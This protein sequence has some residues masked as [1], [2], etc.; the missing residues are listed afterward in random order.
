MFSPWAWNT[1]DEYY[2]SFQT[3]S[4]SGHEGYKFPLLDGDFWLSPDSRVVF[5]DY[6]FSRETYY[7]GFTY[8]WIRIFILQSLTILSSVWILF[9]KWQGTGLMLIPF[10]LSVYSGL[11]GLLLV[12]RYMFVQNYYSGGPSWGLPCAMFSS[13]FFLLLFFLRYGLGRKKDRNRTS[14]PKTQSLGRAQLMVF[15]SH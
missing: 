8:E 3:V 6:W 9:R 13:L 11:S 7:Y 10:F 1:G 15:I 5:L 4:Y 12:A 14:E 2:W